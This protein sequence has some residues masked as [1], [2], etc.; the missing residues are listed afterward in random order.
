MTE[1]DGLLVKCP[2]C[3]IWPMAAS[4]PKGGSMQGVRFKCPRCRHVSGSDLRRRLI[5]QRAAQT[6]RAP[7]AQGPARA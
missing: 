2:Q 6:T 1:A 3:G 4:F 7:S 5:V